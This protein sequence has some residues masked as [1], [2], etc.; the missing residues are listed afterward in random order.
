[1]AQPEKSWTQVKHIAEQ[2]ASLL[3]N[4]I[5]DDTNDLDDLYWSLLTR[6]CYF[7][8]LT[9]TDNAPSFYSYIKKDIAHSSLLFLELPEQ[10]TFIE[11]KLSYMQRTLA[12]A[13]ASSRMHYINNN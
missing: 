10:D 12:T 7:I 3:D 6:Y 1:M 11:S 5:I 8:E 4:N 9:A 13:E 2:L